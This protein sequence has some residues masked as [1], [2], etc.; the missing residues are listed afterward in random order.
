MREEFWVP[1]GRQSV[2]TVTSK[3]YV[4]KRLEGPSCDYPSPPP[5]P[6]FRVENGTPFLTTGV[7]YTGALNIT[8]PVTGDARKV[9]IVLFTCANTRAVHL[10]LAVDL[11]AE[12]FLNV[13]RR[14]VARRSCPQLM[15]SDNGRYF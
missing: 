4:C 10:E 1:Q 15:I 3:C 8:D 2:K 14:F 9:Y 6:P 13:F 5:L 11:T 7:D 12:T